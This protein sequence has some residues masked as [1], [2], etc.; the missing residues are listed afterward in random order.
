MFISNQGVSTD[1]S[2]FHNVKRNWENWKTEIETMQDTITLQHGL[3]DNMRVMNVF[4]STRLSVSQG[5]VGGVIIGLRVVAFHGG[6]IK[7]PSII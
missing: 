6:K 2:F 5:D 7:I 3:N 4:T 1:T